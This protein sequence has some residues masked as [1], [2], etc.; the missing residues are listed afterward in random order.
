M[1]VDADLAG[2]GRAHTEERQRQLRPSRPEQAGEAENLAGAQIERNILEVSGAGQ[3]RDGENARPRGQVDL[4]QIVV[5]L[6][7]RHQVGQPA[8]R[9]LPGREGAELP[10][11]PQH[12]DALCHLEH[13][14]E[15]VADED[16]AD[17]AFLQ[18]PDEPQQGAD[19]LPRERGGR[20]I[21]DDQPRLPG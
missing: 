4:A 5:E 2:I 9:H 14:V 8:V 6:L 10:A 12:R 1:A 20:L 15:L 16:D 19:L 17:P 11:V 13:L 18:L 7:A 21:H 3:L